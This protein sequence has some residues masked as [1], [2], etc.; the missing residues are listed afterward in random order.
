MLY[1]IVIIIALLAIVS[2]PFALAYDLAQP[3]TVK[4]AIHV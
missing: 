4:R 3:V 2:I 1:R